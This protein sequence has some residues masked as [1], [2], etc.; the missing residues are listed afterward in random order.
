[1]SWKKLFCAFSAGALVTGLQLAAVAALNDGEMEEERQLQDELRA[2]TVEQPPQQQLELDPMEPLDPE[3][4][5][6]QLQEQDA[7]ETDQELAPSDS[8]NQSQLGGLASAHGS[9]NLGSLLPSL[10]GN[11]SKGGAGAEKGGTEPDR[12]ARPAHRPTPQYPPEARRK[13]I[14]GVVLL[15][16]RVETDGNVSDVVIVEATPPSIFDNAAKAAARSARFDPAIIAGKPQATTV[17]QRI[18]FRLR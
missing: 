1:M 9:L 18:V 17:E 4:M 13:R 11:G 16:L 15:R 7:S 5:E 14:E 10:V 12:A 2:L 3:P 6:E 8:F